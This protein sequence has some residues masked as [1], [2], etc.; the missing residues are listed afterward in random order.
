MISLKLEPS[1]HDS[2]GAARLLDLTSMRRNVTVT[3]PKDLD[4]RSDDEQMLGGTVA[5][6]RLDRCKPEHC[7]ARTRSGPE[8]TQ[9]FMRVNTFH[10]DVHALATHRSSDPSDVDTRPASQE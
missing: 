4:L 10:S 3:C 6:P 2:R 9:R 7:G 1:W 5:I 8:F